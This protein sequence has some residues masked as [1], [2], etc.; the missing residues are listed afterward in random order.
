MREFATTLCVLPHQVKTA[1]NRTSLAEGPLVVS[2]PCRFS[3]Q[4]NGES[5]YAPPPDAANADLIAANLAGKT[6]RRQVLPLLRIVWKPTTIP[7]RR[8]RRR[9]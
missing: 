2:Q 1:E 8:Q 9:Q 3:Q 7:D 4:V 6:A 5:G